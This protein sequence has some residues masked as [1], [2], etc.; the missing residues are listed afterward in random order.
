MFLLEDSVQKWL[1]N[2]N[3]KKIPVVVQKYKIKQQTK[4]K[5]KK[6]RETERDPHK[7]RKKILRRIQ[8]LRIML[9]WWQI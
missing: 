7:K 2:K 6:R 4:E 9:L 1:K 3:N 8:T 5:N